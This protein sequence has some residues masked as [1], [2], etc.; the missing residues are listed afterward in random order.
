MGV[1][2]GSSKSSGGDGSSE[3]SGD[4]SNSSGGGGLR[5]K[6]Q[7]AAAAAL[8]SAADAEEAG[9]GDRQRRHLARWRRRAL[10]CL[11]P[12][13]SQAKD[14]PGTGA[15][16]K[17][18]WLR[19]QWLKLRLMKVRRKGSRLWLLCTVLGMPR[20]Q[21]LSRPA[22][23]ALA[24]ALLYLDANEVL[25]LARGKAVFRSAMRIELDAEA[26]RRQFKKSDYQELA[27]HYKDK[28]VQVHVMA[29]YAR[30]ALG[31]VRAAMEFIEDYF[32]MDRSGFV[33]RYFAG[34]ADVTTTV[35]DAARRPAWVERAWA[36]IAEE[37]ASGR[38]AFVVAPRIKT[39]EFGKGVV[40][41]AEELSAGPLAGVRVG[42]PG[43]HGFRRATAANML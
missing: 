41:L 5:T 38:Q 12:A 37:V 13:A 21:Q 32:S 29:E 34:R 11:R 42:V 26:R 30:L 27:L 40:E 20:G 35:V 23:I 19:L 7:C 25:H 28:I 15:V 22:P 1:F 10:C 9:G 2:S 43:W 14:T 16:A 8:A 39:T 18:G 6:R 4:E 3:D 33:R 17:P 31:K 24:A 36:R